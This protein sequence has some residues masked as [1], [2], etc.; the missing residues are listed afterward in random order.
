MSL[1]WLTAGVFAAVF[2]TVLSS[3]WLV[4]R[5]ML[6]SRERIDDRVR[7][8]LRDQLRER[9]RESSL[10]RDFENRAKELASGVTTWRSAL[11]DYIAQSGLNISYPQLL[12][13][14]AAAVLVLPLLTSFYTGSLLAGAVAFLVTLAAPCIYIVAARRRRMLKLC[15]Q[16][17]DAFDVMGRALRAGLTVPAAFQTVANEFPAPISDE[18][19]YCFEQQHLGIPF[20]T[21]LRDLARRTGFTETKLFATALIMNQQAG[22]NLVEVL[23]KLAE[24][25]RERSRFQ[26]RLRALT[27]EGRMQAI[28]L[29]GLPLVTLAAMCILNPDYAQVLFDRPLILL[30]SFAS[31][32]VGSICIYWI[33]NFDI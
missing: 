18:F 7:E 10:F 4:W 30:A 22:G 26:N 23:E 16:L 2:L 20:D 17:P 24:T 14:A 32:L 29:T 6:R 8:K 15:R 13:G 12:P 19:S 21:S 5:F 31:Q 9:A 3:R 27:G 33:I 11:Q 25:M 1:D 28:I